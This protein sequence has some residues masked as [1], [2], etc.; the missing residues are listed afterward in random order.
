[1][2][3]L[4][5]PRAAG[6]T[7]T[8]ALVALA[9]LALLLAIGMPRMSNWIAANRAAAAAGFYAEAFTFARAQAVIHN[10][11]SR[12]V[13][14][15]NRSNGQMDWRVDI[16]FPTLA[17]PCND[18]SGAWSTTAA[19]A[20]GDPEGTAGFKSVFRGADGLPGRAVL[21]QTMAPE[22]AS[23]VYFTPL[24]WVDASYDPSLN[25]IDLAPAQAGAFPASAVVLTLAGIASKCDPNAA[26][27]DSR[28]C[29]P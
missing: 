1:M 6:F 11:A 12:L 9:V 16:C 21:T 19:P 7:T 14:S 28:G 17:V 18:S 26:P 3:P 10:S 13:L 25:R 24:G 5:P 20:G 2:H 8:E 27:R 4:S 15:A 23:A 29:P 22:G